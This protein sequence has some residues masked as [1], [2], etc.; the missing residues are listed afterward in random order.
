[1]IENAT[2]TLAR[3]IFSGA[4]HNTTVAGAAVSQQHFIQNVVCP[5]LPAVVSCANVFVS[6]SSFPQ[7]SSPTPYYGY[8]DAA[9]SRVEPPALDNSRNRFCFGTSGSYVV[10]Q[11]S[12]AMPLMTNLLSSAPLVTLNGAK[13]RQLTSTAV[14]RNEPFPTPTWQGC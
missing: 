1:V 2:K 9:Q 4:I 13:V 10:L 11:V 3:Q 8:L 7:S 5:L 6:L 14:F 12:Y